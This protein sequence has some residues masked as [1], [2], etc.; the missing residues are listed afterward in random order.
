MKMKKIAYF[1]SIVSTLIL[2]FSL[3]LH[4]Q[5]AK[6]K[7]ILQNFSTKIKN[8]SGV[9][10]NFKITMNDAKGK[11]TGSYAG[12]IKFKGNKYRVSI[13]SQEII[14]DGKST[15]TYIKNNNEVQIS[16]ATEKTA[17]FSPKDLFAGAYDKDY[18]YKFIGEKTVNGKA[19]N[20][21]ELTP[22]ATNGPFK[23]VTL[24]ITKA[25]NLLAGGNMVGKS[26]ESYNYSISNMTTS[27]KLTDNNFT[28][29]KALYPGVEVIDLR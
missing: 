5:D 25:D 21:I 10:S 19:C 15:W 14:S 2:S 4:A 28:F 29:N 7:T 18:H 9:S 22:K 13:G 1:L 24:H 3:Q 16:S 26:G 11:Q 6:A 20:T 12:T 8:A 17:G 23:K 27:T